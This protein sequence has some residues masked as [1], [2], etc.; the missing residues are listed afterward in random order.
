MSVFTRLDGLNATEPQI[1]ERLAAVIRK[2]GLLFIGHSENFTDHRE[3]NTLRG[4][5][6]YERV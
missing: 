6:V 1:L 5:I 2:G 4:K 3:L